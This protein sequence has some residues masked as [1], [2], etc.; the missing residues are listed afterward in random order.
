MFALDMVPM[1]CE[2]DLDVLIDGDVI[3]LGRIGQDQVAVLVL[4]V[5]LVQPELGDKNHLAYL[6]NQL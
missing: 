1:L 6:I 5:L 3:I 4:L 2:D